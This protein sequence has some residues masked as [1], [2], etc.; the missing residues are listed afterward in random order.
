MTT[1]KSKE[2][3]IVISLLGLTLTTIGIL[4]AT[5][6]RVGNQN[7]LIFGIIVSAVGIATIA[8]YLPLVF[9]KEKNSE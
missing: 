6:F 1:N 9:K 3:N 8:I 7:N 5:V 4:L 2:I